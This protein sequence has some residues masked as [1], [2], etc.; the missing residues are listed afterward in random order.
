MWEQKKIVTGIWD[1]FNGIHPEIYPEHVKTEGIVVSRI[2]ESMDVFLAA[3]ALIYFG[4]AI[5][6]LFIKK[7]S[8]PLPPDMPAW[9][10]PKSFGEL[11]E[12]LSHVLFVML[13]L[14]T[15]EVIWL[16]VGNLTWE[17]L[18]LPAAVVLL[19]VG[20]RVV[21]FTESHHDN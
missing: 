5:F 1:Y 9:L 11:K 15:I 7:E 16:S 20:I 6:N 18:I 2:L 10:S 4:Y 14:L 21:G 12:T 8:E 3:L 17:S 13:L 19:A